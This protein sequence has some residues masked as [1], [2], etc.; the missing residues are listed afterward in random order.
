MSFR[1]RKLPGD[2]SGLATPECPYQLTTGSFGSD[3]SD[4]SDAFSM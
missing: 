4:V 2:V 1:G 3:R